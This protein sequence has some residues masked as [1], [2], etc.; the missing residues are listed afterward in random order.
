MSF[1]PLIAIVGPTA[2]GK[3]AMGIAM[4]HG[5][6]GEIV[7]AD[8]RQVYRGMDIGTAKPT[9][10]QRAAA[11]HHLVDIIHPDEPFSLALYQE[12][13][14]AA[15]GE[16][17]AR[18]RVPL[19][20]GGTGQYLAAVLEG[21]NVPRVEPQRELRAALERE[22]Q[23]QGAAALY[24][25]LVQVDPQAAATISPQNV[26]R[27]V[28]ALEVYE[29]TGQPIS[30]QQTRHPPPYSIATCWLT[31][32]TETLYARIDARV[33]MMMEAGLLEE[34]WKLLEA[35]Y[36]WGLSAMSSLGYVQF[37]P[38][39]EGEAPLEAC[40]QRLKYDTHRFARQQKGWFRRLPGVVRVGAGGIHPPASRCSR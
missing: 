37:R 5:L 9:P 21:W 18:G 39:F 35:G 3:T 36:H 22:A 17:T 19:L 23:E 11:P 13:A 40:V 7:S 27:I 24:D 16:I 8:S 26:R 14:M 25:R 29:V 33:D 38:F 31:L 30:A 20:V 2:V 1:P 34:V 28:R 6:D 10:Q 15:I 4:A 32:P 12:W